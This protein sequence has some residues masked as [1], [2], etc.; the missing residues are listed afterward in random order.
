MLN[1]KF[2]QNEINKIGQF[3]KK[4]KDFRLKNLLYFNE[5]GFPNKRS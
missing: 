4:E 5:V 3:S 2:N 1:F